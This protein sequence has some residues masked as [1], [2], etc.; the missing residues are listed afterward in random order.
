MITPLADI[1]EA[2]DDDGGLRSNRGV[3][4]VVISFM[5][6]VETRRGD[7]GA[8]IVRARRWR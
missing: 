7:G 5:E 6:E 8:V 2:A 1:T 4:S 3:R